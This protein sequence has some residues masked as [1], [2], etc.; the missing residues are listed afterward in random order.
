MNGLPPDTAPVPPKDNLR[1]RSFFFFY[2]L[3]LPLLLQL[4]FGAFSFSLTEWG[5]WSAAFL[6]RSVSGGV[7]L[8]AALKFPSRRQKLFLWLLT[9]GAGLFNLLDL[10]LLFYS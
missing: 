7:L 4:I 5:N 8:W 1:R 10:F 2:L 9:L 3:L 6:F